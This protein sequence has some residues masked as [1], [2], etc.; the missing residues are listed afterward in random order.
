M[1]MTNTDTSRSGDLVARLRAPGAVFYEYGAD[2][3]ALLHSCADRIEAL[4]AE[5]MMLRE[6]RDRLIKF[7]NIMCKEYGLEYD[8]VVKQ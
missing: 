1:A 2:K 8:G 3:G 6:E 4:E 5:N 7:V